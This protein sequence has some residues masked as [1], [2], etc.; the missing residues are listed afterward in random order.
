MNTV[1]DVCVDVSRDPDKTSE[2]L[3]EVQKLHKRLMSGDSRGGKTEGMSA[4]LKDPPV[5]KKVS[6]KNKKANAE[7]EARRTEARIGLNTDVVREPESSVNIWVRDDGTVSYPVE[8]LGSR[9]KST[10]SRGAQRKPT[11]SS[12]KDPP[13]SNS[14]SVNKGNRLKPQYERKSRKKKGLK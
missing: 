7:A 6:A 8:E 14:K 13:V 5:I 3:E 9:L 10:N 2:F 12:L 11:Q 1:N 4:V